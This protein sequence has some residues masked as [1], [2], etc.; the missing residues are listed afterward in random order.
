MAEKVN[1]KA[2][3]MDFCPSDGAYF[4]QV[5]GFLGKSLFMPPPRGGG[6]RPEYSPLTNTTKCAENVFWTKNAKKY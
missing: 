6:F 1:I 2:F 4:C 3:F 5:F